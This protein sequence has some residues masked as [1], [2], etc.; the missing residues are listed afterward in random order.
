M[1]LLRALYNEIIVHLRLRHA[2]RASAEIR[3]EVCEIQKN[4]QKRRMNYSES[5]FILQ[6]L[7]G[8]LNIRVYP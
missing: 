1:R 2:F 6:S 3:R 5:N 4:G 8:N 7:L